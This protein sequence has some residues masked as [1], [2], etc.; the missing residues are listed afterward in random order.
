VAFD[1]LTREQFV[2]LTTFRRDGTKVPTTVWFAHHG[3]GIV[4]GTGANA[5]KV[6]RIRNNAEVTLAPSNYR[7]K[8]KPGPTITGGA[9][10]LEGDDAEGARHALASKY[11][12]Q[13]TLFGRRIDAFIEVAPS[14]P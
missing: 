12:L 14:K 8:L 6:K 10:V 5:G 13:W 9:R 11:G 2:V 4:I 7:G 1:S 3:D